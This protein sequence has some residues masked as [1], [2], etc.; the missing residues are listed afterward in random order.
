V[1]VLSEQEAAGATARMAAAERSMV[2]RVAV[3]GCMGSLAVRSTRLAYNQSYSLTNDQEILLNIV[4]LRYAE[5]PNFM[6][7]PAI[8]SQIE[9]STNGNGESTTPPGLGTWGLR[10]QHPRRA[11]LPA[12]DIPDRQGAQFERNLPLRNREFP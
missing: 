5:S 6:D 1:V 11:Q 3:S 2:R 12:G 4:R 9:A 7:L 10:R 8:T